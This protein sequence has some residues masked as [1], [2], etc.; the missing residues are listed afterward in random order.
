MFNTHYER[1]KSPAEKN[2]GKRHVDKTGFI[3]AQRRIENI[4]NAGRRLV[5]ARSEMYDFPD[6]KIDE[7]FIDPTRSPNFDMADAFQ[8]SEVAKNNMQESKRQAAV[9]A[10]EKA[11]QEQKN[12]VQGAEPPVSA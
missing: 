2:N 3:P 11:Q 5:A 9:K 7:N 6:D 8:L 4:I 10:A 1:K 12:G